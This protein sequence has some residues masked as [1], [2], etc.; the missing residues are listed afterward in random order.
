RRGVVGSWWPVGEFPHVGGRIS[1]GCLRR[2][3]GRSCTIACLLAT[4]TTA[5]VLSSTRSSSHLSSLLWSA[6]WF[7]SARRSTH[8][9]RPLATTSN[10][11]LP[12]A[13]IHPLRALSAVGLRRLCWV[14]RY[15]CF[16]P[17]RWI[18]RTTRNRT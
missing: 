7:C 10:R 18:G 6:V 16:G 15:D 12:R 14:R 4:G 5:R 8:S 2:G 13:R 1:S 3:G 11:L 9:S 17:G